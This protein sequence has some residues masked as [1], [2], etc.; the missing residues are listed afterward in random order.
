MGAPRS[1]DALAEFIATLVRRY[2]RPGARGIGFLEIWNEPHFEHNPIHFWWGSAEQLA[3]MG[4]VIYA[5][6]KRVDPG[7]CVLSPGF[8]DNLTGA[9]S[10]SSL[11]LASARSSSLYQYLSAPDGRG[12]RGGDWCEGIAFHTYEAVIAGASTGIEGSLALL[13][14]MLYQM[15]LSLPVYC[16][17]CGFRPTSTF[18]ASPVEEQAAALRRLAAVLAASRVQGLYFYAHEDNFIGDPSRHSQIGAALSQIHAQLAGTTLRQVT[19]LPGG[20]VRVHTD[21]QTFLC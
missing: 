17:E 1:L 11:T 19:V 15:K 7:I 13:R 4:R 10:F 6:A 12:G 21:H 16:T 9:M 14:A 20:A 18:A 3:T 5:A 2:N 8:D